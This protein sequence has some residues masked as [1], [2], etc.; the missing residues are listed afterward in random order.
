MKLRNLRLATGLVLMLF[1]T[2]HMANLMLGTHSLAA[3]EHWPPWLMGPG[4]VPRPGSSRVLGAHSHRPGIY[5][6][7]TGA[8]AMSKT[9]WCSFAWA[10]P[11]RRSSS[12]T[13]S[14]CIWQARSR[15]ISTATYG[16]MLAVYWSFSPATRCS[17]SALVMVVW[18]HAAVGL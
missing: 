18:I 4:A 3:M 17:S 7:S 5:A 1:V 11:R 9:D 12:T 10:S 6:I 2:G 14:S 8:P 16:Q 13:R 15:R